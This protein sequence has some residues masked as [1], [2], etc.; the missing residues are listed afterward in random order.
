MQFIAL[1]KS[2]SSCPSQDSN[3]TCSNL[4]SLVVDL[5]LIFIH[6]IFENLRLAE[7]EPIGNVHYKAFN[8]KNTFGKVKHKFNVFNFLNSLQIDYGINTSSPVSLLVSKLEILF[9]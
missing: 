1:S 7:A 4:I 6:Y 9:S 5:N 2:V 3:I 8:A